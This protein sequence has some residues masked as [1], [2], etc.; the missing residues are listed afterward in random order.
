MGI[1]PL[2]K[3]GQT[4]KVITDDPHRLPGRIAAIALPQ[5]LQSRFE[6][7]DSSVCLRSL[8]LQ[9]GAVLAPLGTKKDGTTAPFALQ[10]MDQITG[11]QGQAGELVQLAHAA[12]KLQTLYHLQAGEASHGQQ[13]QHQRQQYLVADGNMTKQV[14][15][16]PPRR[17]GSA[18]PSL[19][20]LFPTPQPRPIP[21]FP[22]DSDQVFR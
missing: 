4:G 1:H 9:L 5:R 2:A 20:L 14:H 3:C 7:L 22:H 17:A 10:L 16:D 18:L 21:N 15:D 19:L 11:G 13:R 6:T 8:R 12:G